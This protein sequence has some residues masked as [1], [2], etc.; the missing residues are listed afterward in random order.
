MADVPSRFERCSRMVLL[1][2]WCVLETLRGNFLS[3]ASGCCRKQMPLRT[4]TPAFASPHSRA[5]LIY[6]DATGV[7]FKALHWVLVTACM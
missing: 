4:C 5:P 3:E 7:A 2:L 6:V 1:I